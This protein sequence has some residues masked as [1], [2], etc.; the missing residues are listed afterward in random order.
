MRKPSDVASSLDSLTTGSGHTMQTNCTY[1]FDARGCLA[2]FVPDINGFGGKHDTKA[3][4]ENWL[5]AMRRYGWT[6]NDNL[7]RYARSPADGA[8]SGPFCAKPC[9]QTLTTISKF[10]NPQQYPADNLDTLH[11][12]EKVVQHADKRE[13]ENDGFVCRFFQATRDFRR[14]FGMGKGWAVRM[15]LASKIKLPC[16]APLAPVTETTRMIT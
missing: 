13:R 3:Y 5:S 1:Y 12:G 11:A 10:P 16:Y 9:G 14:R 2:W 6:R 8:L 15:T 7:L 4:C